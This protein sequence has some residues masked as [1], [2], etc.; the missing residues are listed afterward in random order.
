M[1]QL[2][3]QRGQLYQYYF[4][5]QLHHQKLQAQRYLGHGLLEWRDH[6]HLLK[7]LPDHDHVP[8]M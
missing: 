3:S 7:E 6:G 1:D 5:F 4:M 8:K 2:D